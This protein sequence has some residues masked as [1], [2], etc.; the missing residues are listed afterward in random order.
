MRGKVEGEEGRGNEERMK[1]K[2]EREG[3][4]NEGRMK[5][6]VEGEE[7]RG[8]QVKS[9]AGNRVVPPNGED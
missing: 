9:H 6:K 3:R 7:G 5:G 4:G 2:V 1:G 8:K